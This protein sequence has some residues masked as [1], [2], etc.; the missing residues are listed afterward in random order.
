MAGVGDHMPAG[1]DDLARRVADLEKLV[2]RLQ[3]VNT[4]NAATIDKGTLKV[5][6]GGSFQVIDPSTGT[7]IAYIGQLPFNDGSGRTQGGVVLSRAD[8]SVALELGDFGLIPGHTFQQA[9]QWKSR[10]G[11][12]VIADDTVS[13]NGLAIPYIPAGVFE[14]LTAP[15]NT[16]TSATFVGMQWA[17]TYQ[18]HPK[19]TA[20][21]LV[22]VPSG[23]QADIR[24]TVSGQQIGSIITVGS[25]SFGQ[26]TIPAAAWPAGTY[27][28]GQ[29]T[30]VQLE[31][32]RTVGTGAIGVRGLG[33]WGVQS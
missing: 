20:S 14:D 21:V 25:G 27:T 16:T 33:L 13:G 1:P 7:V 31:A 10:L 23:N 2:Q 18:Q 6:N 11:Q 24:M 30:V 3:A 22:Q 26:F 5:I 32:R 9:L 8:G 28:F 19:V 15:T 4:F 29:R 12:I 17:D